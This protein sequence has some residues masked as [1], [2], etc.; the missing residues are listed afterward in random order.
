MG[1]FMGEHYTHIRLSLS[2]LENRVASHAIL[3][4]NC[5]FTLAIIYPVFSKHPSSENNKYIKYNDLQATNKLMNNWYSS[6][7]VLG[8]AERAINTMVAMALN[9]GWSY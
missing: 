2:Q 5:R 4:R 1:F 7:V 8:L 3:G 6:C 9:S